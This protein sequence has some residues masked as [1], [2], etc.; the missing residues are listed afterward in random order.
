M[1]SDYIDCYMKNTCTHIKDLFSLSLSVIKNYDFFFVFFVFSRAASVAYG[2][3][4][5][6]DQIGPVA[7][8]LRQSYSNA[9]S[10]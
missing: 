4:Q 10:E 1:V 3:S 2:G 7:A 6:R 9:R 5:A 8:S